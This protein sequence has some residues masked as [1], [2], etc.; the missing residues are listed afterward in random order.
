MLPRSS[1]AKNVRSL[2]PCAKFPLN[3][4]LPFWNKGL[5]GDN[6]RRV[7]EFKV[8]RVLGR[9][10]VRVA[11]GRCPM[12]PEPGVAF[13]RSAECGCLHSHTPASGGDPDDS[14]EGW[15]VSSGPRDHWFEGITGPINPYPAA[16]RN[17]I[18]LPLGRRSRAVP[19]RPAGEPPRSAAPQA[20]T[21]RNPQ[22]A[23]KFFSRLTSGFERVGRA[24]RPRPPRRNSA[25]AAAGNAQAGKLARPPRFERAPERPLGGPPQR[26]KAS[27]RRSRRR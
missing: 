3:W 10:C 25:E 23:T 9:G 20:E 21:V 8:E 5:A 24:A 16:S 13:G 4:R 14:I 27:G 19:S 12:A 1:A 2:R 15:G 22:T 17:P 11:R 26:I 6:A 7:F 18:P